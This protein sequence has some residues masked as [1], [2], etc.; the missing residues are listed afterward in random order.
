MN[1]KQC[2]QNRNNNKCD[3]DRTF[4]IEEMPFH[5]KVVLFPVG[6]NGLL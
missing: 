4:M 2:E 6:F 1:Q 5:I 3:L